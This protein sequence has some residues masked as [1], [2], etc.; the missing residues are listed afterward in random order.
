[1]LLIWT[2]RSLQLAKPLTTNCQINR[3]LVEFHKPPDSSG[4][5]GRTRKTQTASAFFKP[6]IHLHNLDKPNPAHSYS[7][8]SHVKCYRDSFHY[9]TSHD[10]SFPTVVYISPPF[11]LN[12]NILLCKR[13]GTQRRTNVRC[14]SGEHSACYG[15]GAMCLSKQILPQR[16]STV[17][18]VPSQLAALIPQLKSKSA[19]RSASISNATTL[20]IQLY[21]IT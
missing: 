14:T 7:L 3:G 1:M 8:L 4:I 10:A 11:T 5:S 17:C 18:Y 13:E 12:N 19:R 15:N 16:R 20:T 6:I 2:V 9:P 21:L